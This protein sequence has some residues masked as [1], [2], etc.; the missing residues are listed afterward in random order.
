MIHQGDPGEEFF[1]V[2]SGRLVV[3]IDGA[4]RAD[5]E[6]GDAFGEIALLRDVPRSAT[7]RA[8]TDSVLLVVDR[9]P[10]LTAVT[11]HAATRDLN[12]SIVDTHLEGA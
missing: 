3:T 7:V 4:A 10:F 12:S 2:I 5:L 1:T 11:G 6:R 9:E 8:E